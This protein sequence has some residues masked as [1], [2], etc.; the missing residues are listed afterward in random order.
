MSVTSAYRY[1]ECATGKCY[2]SIELGDSFLLKYRCWSFVEICIVKDFSSSGKHAGA[3]MG[4]TK[5]TLFETVYI[6]LLSLQRQRCLPHF[7]R[8]NKGEKCIPWPQL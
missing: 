2:H 7:V 4:L 1:I 5:V 8:Q 6:I 3:A